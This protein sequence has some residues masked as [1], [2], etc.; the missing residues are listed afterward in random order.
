MAG[1]KLLLGIL[2]ATILPWVL[3]TLEL[4][5]VYGAV[6]NSWISVTGGLA[7]LQFWALFSFNTIANYVHIP[8]LGNTFAILILIWI[9]SG[10]IVGVLTKDPKTAV[11]SVILGVIINMTIFLLLNIISGGIPASL[12]N[13][14]LL[15]L[16]S[17]FS[18]FLI[19]QLIVHI[20]LISF[21]LPSGLLGGLLGG[22]LNREKEI[23]GYCRYIK[24]ISG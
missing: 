2:I 8:L 14:S 5:F 6:L 3:V 12:V 24:R 18:V 21:I 19:I 9:V 10:L 22:I 7:S 15:N 23:E 4:V 13:A 17:S 1:K 11:I 20:T 16:V